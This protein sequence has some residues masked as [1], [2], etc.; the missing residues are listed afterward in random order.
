LAEPSPSSSATATTSD[1]YTDVNEVVKDDANVIDEDGA[2]AVLKL[3]NVL[4]DY[5]VKTQVVVVTV[6]TPPDNESL[7]AYRQQYYQKID[8][9][10]NAVNPD[11]DFG[12]LVV[13]STGLHQYSVQLGDSIKGSLN[14]QLSKDFVKSGSGLGYLQ[15]GNY[16]QAVEAMCSNLQSV[17]TT[18]QNGSTSSATASPSSSPSATFQY[19]DQSESQPISSDD[20]LSFFKTL[21]I[22]VLILGVGI[23]LVAAVVKS[24]KSRKRSVRLGKANDYLES[25]FFND[26]P[27]PSDVNKND[28]REFII[29]HADLDSDESMRSSGL[30]Y[31][32]ENVFPD[33]ASS[34]PGWD[35][36]V[37]YVGYIKDHPEMLDSDHHVD[38]A[39]IVS[40]A[41]LT[42]AGLLTASDK[43]SIISSIVND[44]KYSDIGTLKLKHAVEDW[45][46]QNPKSNKT[47]IQEY[48]NTA[49]ADMRFDE[50]FARFKSKHFM[51]LG[52]DFNEQEFKS[53]L[54]S[55]P[56]YTDYLN[57]VVDT[58]DWMWQEYQNEQAIKGKK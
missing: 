58:N 16:S 12:I 36:N 27:V 18:Y 24:F 38:L 17:M 35:E 32:A 57:G 50:D 41:N 11:A 4:R 6:G 30:D 10:K 43:K 39:K 46:R 26:V 3:N 56:R 51:D 29:G 40:D 23:G 22:A 55:N 20:I 53:I 44:T 54:H 48:A 28:I 21:G 8:W 52:F 42:A 45:M 37:N 14:T 25:R 49:A 5:K 7:D 19:K 31:W 47:Q 15:S 13:Y 1:E 33:L 2:N 34:Q 9:R